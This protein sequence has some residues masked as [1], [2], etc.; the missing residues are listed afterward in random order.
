V[1]GNNNRKG[2]SPTSG[3]GLATAAGGQ[4]NPQWVE[5][6][7]GFQKDWTRIVGQPEEGKP[8]TSGKPLVWSRKRSKRGATE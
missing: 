5:S 3:D 8:S 2:A 4:I 1:A 6:L 7:M